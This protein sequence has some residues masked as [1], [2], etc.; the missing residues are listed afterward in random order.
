MLDLTKHCLANWKP[1]MNSATIHDAKTH[2]S[3]LIEQ[4]EGGDE[5]TILRGK[6][7]V[8]RLVPVKKRRRR[9][10]AIFKNQFRVGPEFFEPLPEEELRA[11]N[12]EGE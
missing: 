8:A 7:A 4:V 6:I 5:I 12:C 9:N 10:L 1:E 3:R 11:W 2:L